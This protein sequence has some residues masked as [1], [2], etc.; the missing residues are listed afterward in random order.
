MVERYLDGRAE[1]VGTRLKLMCR[2]GCL[3][4]M[5]RLVREEKM[6]R[7]LGVCK[8]CG[9]GAEDTRHLLLTCSTHATHRA[10]MVAGVDRALGLAGIAPLREQAD[11]DQTDILLGKTTGATETDD[12][13]NVNVTRFLKKAWRGRKWLTSALN[14]SLRR[15]DTE[16][17][18]KAHGDRGCRLGVPPPR[19]RR[20]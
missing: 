9:Q 7:E 19:F 15:N 1:P 5:T 17:A 20:G 14:K 11:A 10:K 8:L 13:V 18:L 16:W 6:P 3:P 2:M 12:R 4:T